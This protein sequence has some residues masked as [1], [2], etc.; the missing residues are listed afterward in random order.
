MIFLPLISLGVWID[1]LPWSFFS[2]FSRAGR[3]L[4]QEGSD[5]IPQH[6]HCSSSTSTKEGANEGEEE[7]SS[8]SSSFSSKHLVKRL[9]KTL[10]P[11]KKVSFL[12]QK[13]KKG[14][15]SSRRTAQKAAIMPDAINGLVFP[16]PLHS[17][18]GLSAHRSPLLPSYCSPPS[19]R[20]MC[21]YII[22]MITLAHE[23]KRKRPT[24][25]SR[26]WKIHLP[27]LSRVMRRMFF[28]NAFS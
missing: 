25:R 23:E 27:S 24:G 4:S 6:R 9:P 16:P 10:P 15:N 14:S 7:S 8:F 22:K 5:I 17:F 26:G 1:N 13:G 11:T 19:L 28:L 20:G 3:L 12:Y 18:D 21:R 2:S